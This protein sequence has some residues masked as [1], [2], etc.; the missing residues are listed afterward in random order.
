MH[1]SLNLMKPT[2]KLITYSEKSKSQQIKKIEITSCILSDPHALKLGINN[3][4]NKDNK[5]ME[6]AKLS[7]EQKMGRQKLRKKSKTF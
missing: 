4:R 5:L 3:N 7:T 6:T 2:P 1:S